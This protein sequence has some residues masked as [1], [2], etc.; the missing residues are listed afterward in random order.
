MAGHANYGDAGGG[1]AA[2]PW[3]A[4]GGGGGSPVQIA[5]LAPV[6]TTVAALGPSNNPCYVMALAPRC[7]RRRTQRTRRAVHAP[8]GPL[9][10]ILID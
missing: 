10:N 5:H 4:G 7:A 2:A 3:F 9:H 8:P 1:G 6:S